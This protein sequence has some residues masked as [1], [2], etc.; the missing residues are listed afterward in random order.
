MNLPYRDYAAFLSEHFSGKMQKISIDAGLSCPNRDGT[1][2][3]GGCSYCNNATFSPDYCRTDNSVEAQLE[4]G[5]SF[6]SRK[7]A[8]MRYLA[9]FQSYTGTHGNMGMISGMYRAALGYPGVEGLIIGTRPDCVPDSVLNVLKEI[10]QD[11]GKCIMLEFGAESSH[12]ETLSSVNRC[13]TWEQVVDAVQR[14]R[15]YGFPAGLHLINGL[16]GETPEMMLATVD[17]V[18]N[19]DIDTVKFHQLQ[20]IRGTRLARQWQDGLVGLHQFSLDEYVEHCVKIV[21]RLR[22]G[23]AIDRFTSQSPDG[24]LISPRWG[25]KNYQF[26][27][28]LNNRLVSAGITQGCLLPVK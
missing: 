20:L 26:V 11:T 1:F 15:R 7:Y 16:P 23:I 12:N 2:S 28:L 8:E 9:Y 10:R 22:Q 5:V 18:N 13:H 6:F 25:V 24:L 27:N 3:T 4:K 19:L 21:G 17:A 14:T